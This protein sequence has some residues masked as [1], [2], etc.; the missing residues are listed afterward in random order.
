[1]SLYDGLC[2]CSS[3]QCFMS[4]KTIKLCVMALCLS[5]QGCPLQENKN[6]TCDTLMVCQEDRESYCDPPGPGSCVETC[7]YTI[8]EA[9]WEECKDAAL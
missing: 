7:Y 3:G 1:M 8:Y 9:C 4:M 5:L 2:C 6:K